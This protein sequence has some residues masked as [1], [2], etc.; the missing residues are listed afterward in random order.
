MTIAQRL[1]PEFEREMAVTRTTLERVPEDRMPW[2][3]HEK[4]YTLGALAT[5]IANLASWGVMTVE[6]D[7]FDMSPGGAEPQRTEAA[8]RV[9]EV[10]ETFDANVAAAR[11]AIAA[12]DDDAMMAPWSLLSDG[13]TVFTMPRIAVLRN[14]VMNHTIHH[15]AQLC[16]YLRLNDVPVPAIYGPSAD[17]TGAPAAS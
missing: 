16:V 5:H 11:A 2:R 7:G 17:E 3:P 13:E 12:C 6:Q 9:A 14:W 1:M 10:L 4:S 8:T 15:R